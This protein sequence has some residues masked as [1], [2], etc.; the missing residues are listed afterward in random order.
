VVV[1]VK[2]PVWSFHTVRHEPGRALLVDGRA[3]HLAWSFRALAPAPV[4]PN[5]RARWALECNDVLIAEGVGIPSFPM[6]VALV[7]DALTPYLAEVPV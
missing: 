1:L 5:D 2:G 4:F 7:V 3:G 6:A